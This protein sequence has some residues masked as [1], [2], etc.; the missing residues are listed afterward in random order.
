MLLATLTLSSRIEDS[1]PSAHLIKS[2]FFR[3]LLQDVLSRNP[4]G[5]HFNC[6]GPAKAG[7]VLRH[8]YVSSLGWR[9]QDVLTY[10]DGDDESTQW[11]T[12]FLTDE[13]VRITFLALGRSL[14]TPYS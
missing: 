13:S 11:E 5:R 12:E 8:W 9:S 3:R 1:Y 2:S 10:L 7:A 6:R 4:T 14:L